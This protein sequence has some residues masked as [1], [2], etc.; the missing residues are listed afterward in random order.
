MSITLPKGWAWAKLE[1][2]AEINPKYNGDLRDE[3][4][5]TFVPMRAVEEL[6]GHVDLSISRKLSE[7]KKGY[8]PFENE[9]ILFA[10]ITPCMENGKV[11]IV[12]NLNNGL[13]FGST[14]FH[15][16]R[17]QESIARKF[18]FFFL[19]REELRKDA[20]AHM[21]GS[22]GQKRVPG[23]YMHEMMVPLPP[24]YEQYRIAAKIEEFLTRMDGGM[25]FL[26]DAKKKLRLYRQALLKHAFEGKLTQT[27]RTTWE[28][29]LEPAHVL[30]RRIDEES[31]KII[32]NERIGSQLV[33]L[34]NLP[35]PPHWVWARVGQVVEIID[36]RGRT[37]PFS[38]TG[39]PHI[40]TPNVKDG[41]IVSEDMKYVSEETYD[42]YMTRGLPQEGD[43]LFT[44]EAPLGE[45]AP[46][47]QQRF[48][49][50]QRIMILRP[51]KMILT[52]KFLMYQIMSGTFQSILR[53][54]GTGTT[55][56]G[57]SSRNF[58]ALELLVAPLREQEKVVEKLENHF[59]V[60][61]E[62]ERIVS[63]N[64]KLAENMRKSILREA[65]RGALVK[66]DPRD[67]QA[68]VLLERIARLKNRHS[69][70]GHNHS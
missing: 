44:T 22:V 59:S 36:Y 52:T 63:R 67:E 25:E 15:V 2:I 50:A 58:K 65:F 61:D 45:V 60:E 24:Q 1:E 6:T 53:R 4:E 8:V 19:V 42:K 26:V 68:S 57:V 28:Q 11:A 69:G 56:T 55:V 46:V 29:E 41:A 32:G 31:K 35:P 12:S 47:P 14:E 10:K 3:M 13:G 18:M 70:D 48:S 64:L 21:T 54:R 49:I 39:I 38:P 40:R 30:Q 27:W 34:P 62:T 43:L 9:D 16:I 20:Q 7:V 23:S 33:T 37:P 51:L 5:V 17:P 66:Q